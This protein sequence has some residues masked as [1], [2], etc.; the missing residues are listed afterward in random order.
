MMEVSLVN[1]E[2]EPFSIPDAMFDYDT[3]ELI[4]RDVTTYPGE[5]V[6]VSFQLLHNCAVRAVGMGRFR[7]Q[8]KRSPLSPIPGFPDGFS[9]EIHW[10]SA[11]GYYGAE[12]NGRS[13]A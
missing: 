9:G 11:G 12:K 4:G 5:E 8:K 13:A 2:E 6:S 7:V 10:V 3:G 1:E